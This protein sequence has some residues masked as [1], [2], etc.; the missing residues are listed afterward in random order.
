MENVLFL[1][2]EV[3]DPYPFYARMQ[4][5]HPVYYDGHNKIWAVYTYQHCEKVLQATQ[6][7][8]PVP[9]SKTNKQP[10][11]NGIL[12]NLARLSNGVHHTKTRAAAMNLMSH[13]K[14]CD[15]PALLHSLMGEPRLPATFDWVSSIAKRLPAFALLKGFDLPTNT[16]L[17]LLHEIENLIKLMAPVE[18]E[19]EMESILKSVHNIQDA[20]NNHLVKKLPAVDD[21]SLYVANFIGLLIQSY[22]ASR[23]LLSNSLLHF[24]SRPNQRPP[25][26]EGFALFV[27]ESARLDPAVHN[28]RRIMDED[29]QVGKYTIKRGEHVLIVLASANRDFQK[30]HQP[31]SL[32][33]DRKNE[34][35]SF[36]SG[37]HKCIAENFSI[38]VTAQVLHY[39]NTKYSKFTIQEHE[40][41]YEPRINVRLP[42]K[43]TLIT[44]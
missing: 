28:T 30:F 41:Q 10:E 22:D 24:V 26:L 39:L 16:A 17:A 44:S 18:D 21:K 1:Q 11:L 35:L 29:M 32:M 27:K 13:W 12:T 34:T 37:I 43:I 40:I 14:S 7:Q 19:K 3:R 33:P 25:T 23:G 9:A 5:E 31:D 4:I 20:F 8:I 15:V 36:G 2:S 38:Q 42:G 6:S